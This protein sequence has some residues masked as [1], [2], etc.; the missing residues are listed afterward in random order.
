MR[1][2]R[3]NYKKTKKNSG[4]AKT[5]LSFLAMS[6]FVVIVG[7]MLANIIIHF[8]PLNDASETQAN[9]EAVN[10]SENID[11]REAENAAD[12]SEDVQASSAVDNST[13][14]QENVQGSINTSFMAIQCGYFANEDNAKEAYNKIANGY[15]AFIYN[16]SDKFKVLAGVYT[17]AEGQSIMDTLTSSGID[18][19]K[20]SFDLNSNDKVQSQ[21][22]GIYNGYLNILDTAFKDDVKSVDTS[23]FKSWVKGL[24]VISEGDKNDVLTELKNHVNDMAAEIKKED[25]ANEMQYLYKILLSFS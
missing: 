1:Y 24:D 16:E 14:G 25:V 19:A 7:I 15:G 5:I 21:I 2:T 17:T 4:L 20:V 6:V 8:L 22:A 3:Y 10:Q 13:E 23:D 11:N 12:N 18:C 9:S